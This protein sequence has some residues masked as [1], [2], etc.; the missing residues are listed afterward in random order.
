[1]K[2]KNIAKLVVLGGLAFAGCSEWNPF[3]PEE[4]EEEVKNLTNTEAVEYLNAKASLKNYDKTEYATN[5]YTY[6]NNMTLRFNDRNKICVDMLC[7][8]NNKYIGFEYQAEGDNKETIDSMVEI[9]KR[10]GVTIHRIDPTPYA[11]NI[12]TEVDEKL[13]E[14][15]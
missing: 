6:T 9:A 7:K 11:H 5:A 4:E 2:T 10:Y 12:L 1:M 3:S 13:P 14:K 15:P 8:T